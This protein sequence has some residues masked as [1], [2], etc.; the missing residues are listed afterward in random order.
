MNIPFDVSGFVG[1]NADSNMDA[2]VV[3]GNSFIDDK[4]NVSYSWTLSEDDV[5]DS[6]HSLG[7]YYNF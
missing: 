3:L 6:T 2:G 4:V 7:V 1:R 5:D